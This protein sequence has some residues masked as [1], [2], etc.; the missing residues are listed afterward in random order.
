[1]FQLFPVKIRHLLE[2]QDECSRHFRTMIRNYNSGLAM[3]SMTAN[4]DI[5]RG[6]GPYCFRVHARYIT[7]SEP[8]DL[9]LDNHQ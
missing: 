5:P 4:I 1:M 2:G 7:P 6:G 8:C 3:A 9:F